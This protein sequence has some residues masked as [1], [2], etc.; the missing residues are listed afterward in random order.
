MAK[1]SA[2]TAALQRNSL[3][4]EAPV[5]DIIDPRMPN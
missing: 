2:P 3:R 1:V 5:L 4:I